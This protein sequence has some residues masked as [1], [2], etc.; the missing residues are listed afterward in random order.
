MSLYEWREFL[1]LCKLAG[2][3]KLD[4]V[5]AYMRKEGINCRQLFN[6]L[7]ALLFPEFISK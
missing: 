1:F 5:F 7:D 3:K 2:F 6:E 4:E